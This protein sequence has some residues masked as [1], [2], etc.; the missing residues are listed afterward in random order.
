MKSK[1]ENFLITLEGNGWGKFLDELGY[2]EVSL[3]LYH[4]IP[5]NPTIQPS[6]IKSKRFYMVDRN[7]I[8]GKEQ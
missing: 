3:P 6:E 8:K 7:Q 2:V 4:N 5:D 1:Y